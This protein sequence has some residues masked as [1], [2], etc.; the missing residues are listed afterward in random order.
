MN[1]DFFRVLRSC[2][3][4]GLDNT[5]SL[6]LPPPGYLPSPPPGVKEIGGPSSGADYWIAQIGGPLGFLE[7][8][9]KAIAAYIGDWGA[10]VDIE[11]L[12][13]KITQA[14]KA[15]E[16]GERSPETLARYLAQ[17]DS[18]ANAIRALQG[19]T[20]GRL[21]R[22]PAPGLKRVDPPFPLPTGTRA[23][24]HAAIST[25]IDDFF[26]FPL[27]WGDNRP[28][29]VL[30]GGLTGSGKSEALGKKLPHQ[31]AVWRA[32]NREAKRR[33]APAQ[34]HRVIVAVETHHLG[35]QIAERYRAIIAAAGLAGKI[36]VAVFEGRGDPF[37]SDDIPNREY[38]C[39]NLKEVGLAILAKADVASTVCGNSGRGGYGVDPTEADVPRCPFRDECG[40]FDQIAD[41]ADADIVIVAHNFVFQ[42]LPKAILHD[43]AC[44][45]I[46]EDFTEHGFGT[47]ELPVVTFYDTALEKH[48]VLIRR[49]KLKGHPDHAR[50]AE[51][52][53]LFSKVER[54]IEC[55]ESGMTAV[56]AVETAG[57]TATDCA[58][59]RALDWKRE[60]DHKMHP[61]MPLEERK[62]RAEACA[63]NLT[64]PRIAAA[65]HA[66]EEIAKAIEARNVDPSVGERLWVDGHDLIVPGLRQP[67]KWLAELPV[68]IASATARLGLVQ[69]FFP[70][71]EHVAPPIPALPHQHVHQILGSFGK[72]ATVKKI[73]DLITDYRLR[74]LGSHGRNLVVT[75]KAYESGFKGIAGL[76]T[77]HHGDV[78][79]DDDYGDVENLF[80][81]GGPFARPRDIA[82]RASAETRRR[83]LEAKPVR[84]LCAG[85]LIIGQG[86]AFERLAYTDPDAMTVHTDIYDTAIVQAIGRGRG[87]NRTERTPLEVYVYGNLPLP[88]PVTTIERWKRPSRLDKMFLAGH[89]P[90]NAAVMHRLYPELF[91]SE[92]AAS[93]ARERWGGTS[94]IEARVHELA[95]RA[96]APWDI[97]LCQ[98]DGK[99]RKARHS[100]VKRDRLAK[101]EAAVARAFGGPCRIWNAQPLHRPP[102]CREDSDIPR[103]SDL[104]L[105]MSESSTHTKKRRGPPTP[106]VL[107]SVAPRAPPRQETLF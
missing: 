93:K 62:A 48:P 26:N 88:I 6:V 81:M 34:P 9:K 15:A 27:R 4:A 91:P 51:L 22:D 16:A 38:L 107:R 24:V 53:G 106:R 12:R 42:S 7:P 85:M 75:H 101:A 77:R 30:L 31:I 43:L 49:G 89:V 65:L 96:G 61:G 63:H 98:P 84:T 46:E 21:V 13:E 55:L 104:F 59:A 66:L 92:R 36:T 10:E 18:I 82:S 80:V 37:P 95:E 58:Q 67:D 74:T 50:T 72:S 14:F 23:E 102:D 69:K 28:R 87:I 103:K 2:R 20:P 64:L 35:A 68:I 71:V 40:Y 52:D 5:L 78:A 60:V 45:I 105:G 99:G 73:D 94:A 70:T 79:G 8:M 83:V 39:K 100:F 25:G 11:P 90:T 54:V 3:R 57:L 32:K 47:V 33:K 56:E 76:D 17:I 86:F 44:V 19:G 97:V 41:C 29:R 1:D